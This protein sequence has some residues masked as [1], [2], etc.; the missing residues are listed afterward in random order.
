[1]GEK[2]K[3]NK[4]KCGRVT[5]VYEHQKAYWCMGCGQAC[6]SVKTVK[7]T[8]PGN[9]KRLKVNKNNKV[10]DYIWIKETISDSEVIWKM[11][12][13]GRIEITKTK[14]GCYRVWDNKLIDTVDILPDLKT[15]KLSAEVYFQ[16]KC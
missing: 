16:V 15:A 3:E 6:K 7:G 8:K 10:I 12:H 5:I 1:M 14:R 2:M 4:C 11:N 9:R 13:T